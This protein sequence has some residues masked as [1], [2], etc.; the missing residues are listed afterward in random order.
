V[1]PT[2]YT[3][4]GLYPQS[5]LAGHVQPDPRIQEAIA[6]G[7][8]PESCWQLMKEISWVAFTHPQR[9]FAPAVGEN[10]EVDEQCK[11]SGT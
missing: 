10:V 11:I 7:Q 2:A 8:A 6:C 3:L 5:A 1:Y 4:V 9:D